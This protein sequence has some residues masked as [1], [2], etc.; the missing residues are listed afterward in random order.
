MDVLR[1]QETGRADAWVVCDE[2]VVWG[3]RVVVGG[4]RAVVGVCARGAAGAGA[5]T[6]PAPGRLRM[7]SPWAASYLVSVTAKTWIS[8]L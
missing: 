7:W 3:W 1:G 5:M 8:A 4:C 2:G 6:T